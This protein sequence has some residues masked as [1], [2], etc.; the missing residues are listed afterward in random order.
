MAHGTALTT[1][2][3]GWRTGQK[4]VPRQAKREGKAA[5]SAGH[6][7]AKAGD[8][9]ELNWLHLH[10]KGH[11]EKGEAEDERNGVEDEHGYR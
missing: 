5:R 3:G 6:A 2:P 10:D 7:E 4:H 11:R 9:A 8:L 1:P